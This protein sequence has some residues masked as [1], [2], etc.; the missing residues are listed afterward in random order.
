MAN[1]VFVGQILLV[2]VQFPAA[3]LRVLPGTAPA[4][5]RRT[6]RSSRCS[7]RLTAATATTNFALPNLQ[8]GFPLGFG[9]GPGL[10]NRDLGE[11]GGTETITLSSAQ[12]PQHTHAMRPTVACRNG[13]GNQQTPVNNVPGH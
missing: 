8:G 2:P 3:R 4:A 6:R 5:S 7:A 11:T 9:Q 13:A 10:T 1:D 12:M